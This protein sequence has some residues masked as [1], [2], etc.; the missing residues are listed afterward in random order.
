VSA[1]PPN[2]ELTL[3]TKD[4]KRAIRR[5]IPAQNDHGAP[6]VY[7]DMISKF[8]LNFDSEETARRFEKAFKHAVQMSQASKELF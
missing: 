3:S 8:A 6:R 5:T 1:E 7:T 2:N 4:G